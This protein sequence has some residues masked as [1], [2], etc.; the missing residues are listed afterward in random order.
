MQLNSNKISQLALFIVLFFGLI[1]SAL[2]FSYRQ[3][4]SIDIVL[5]TDYDVSMLRDPLGKING[6][7]RIIIR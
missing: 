2:Y 7:Q 6:R 4:A 1:L 5:E 3:K